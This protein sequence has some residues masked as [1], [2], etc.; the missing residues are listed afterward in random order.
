MCLFSYCKLEPVMRPWK[1]EKS[2]KDSKVGNTEHLEDVNRSQFCHL[3]AV[4]RHL[5]DVNWHLDGVNLHTKKHYFAVN[6]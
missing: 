3:Q 1:R 6:G 2:E 5:L 4:N